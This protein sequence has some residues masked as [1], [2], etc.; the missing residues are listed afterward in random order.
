MPVTFLTFDRRTARWIIVA[1][2]C[3]MSA[4][5]SIQT[6]VSE[7]KQPQNSFMVP[8][9]T[10]SKR[11]LAIRAPFLAK[12]KPQIKVG[13]INCTTLPIVSAFVK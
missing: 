7:L 3:Q 10:N 9:R 2:I 8:M 1:T 5:P 13:L 4:N 6:N 11:L 12:H